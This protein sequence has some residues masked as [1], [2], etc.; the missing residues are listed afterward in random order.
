M[1]KS[2]FYLILI[3]FLNRSIYSAVY[4]GDEDQARNFK[5]IWLDLDYKDNEVSAEDK[6][7]VLATDWSHTPSIFNDQD[8]SFFDSISGS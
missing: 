8:K 5:E 1:N 4:S 7:F 2:F 6:W 3:I